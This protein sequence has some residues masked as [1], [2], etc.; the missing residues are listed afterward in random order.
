MT[1][2][3]AID[4]LSN[5]L[6]C[7]ERNDDVNCDRKCESCDLVM[8]ADEIKDAYNFAIKIL[9]EPEDEPI[10]NLGQLASRATANV[11]RKIREDDKRLKNPILAYFDPDDWLESMH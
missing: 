7:V 3:R 1:R 2:Q 5:E 9:Q 8:D 6:K 11:L 10:K 4:I